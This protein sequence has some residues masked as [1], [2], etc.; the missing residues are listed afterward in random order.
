MGAKIRI[1]FYA[2]AFLFIS[3]GVAQ[4]PFIGLVA[5]TSNMWNCYGYCDYNSNCGYITQIV[6]SD[7]ERCADIAF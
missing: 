4:Q 6:Q 1:M 3:I 5:P 2:V 7:S